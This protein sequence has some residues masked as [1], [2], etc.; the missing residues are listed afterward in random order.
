MCM[1]QQ[2]GGI[3]GADEYGT[4]KSI[5]QD[6]SNEGKITAKYTGSLNCCLA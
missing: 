1:Y 2:V 5:I 4:H 6:C 3:V